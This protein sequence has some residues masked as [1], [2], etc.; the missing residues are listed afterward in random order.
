M[1]DF[2]EVLSFCDVHDIGFSG[3]PWTFDNKQRGERNVKVRLD[4]AVASPDWSIRFPDAKVHHLVSSRSDHCPLLVAMLPVREV[5]RHHQIRRYEVMWEREPSLA[6]TVEDAWSRRVGVHDLGDI[7]S[8]FHTIMGSLYDWKKK[9]FKPVS[10]EIEKKR[11]RL[12]EL[13]SLTDDDSIAARKQLMCEMDELLYRE[14]LMWMQRSR[15]AWLREGDRN[16]R[17][18]HRKATWRRKKNKILKLKR[19]DGSWAENEEEIGEMATSFF[20]N[21]YTKDDDVLPADLLHLFSPRVDDDMN[22]TLC[23]PFSEK[24]I[25]DALFQIGPLKAP[26]PDGFPARFLQRNWDLLKE[27]IIKAVQAF[28]SSGEMPEVVND[29]AIILIPKKNN[30]EELKDFRPISLCNVVFKI[31]SKCMV[32]RLRPLLHD[33]ISPMQSA[34][35]PGRLITDNALMAFECFHAI[36]SNS[37]D[38]SKFCAY[39]L[40]LAKAYD[41]VDW[42]YLEGVMTKLGFH[43]TWVRWIMQC[44]TTV[45]YSVRL[46]G[47]VLD[48]F[49]PTRGLRQG[50]PLSPYLFLL[51]ADGLS[52]LIQKE[53]EDGNLKELM[54]CR[55]APGM[56]HLLFADDSLLFF[57]G[58]VQQA[59][60][61]KSILNKYEKGTGQLVS[62][63]KCSIMYGRRVE[64]QAQ[65]EIKQILQYETESFD[66]KYLGLPV[67]EGQ[68]RKGKFKT[69]KERFQKRLSDW[70]EKYLSSGGKEVLIKAILQA[71][72]VYA[73]SVFQFPAGLVE[74]LN[75][76]IRNFH[77]GDEHDRRRMHWLSWDKLTQPK[78]NGGMGFRDFRVY[79][80]ALLARQA[81]RL[82]QFPDSPC[83]RLLKAKYYPSGHLL[84]TAF[85]QDVSATWKGVMHGLELLKQGAIW[86]VGSGSMVKIWR[87]N[88][89]PRAD[90]LKLSG[91]KERC[92]LKWVSQLIDPAT[93]TWDEATIRQ[94]CFPH[95]GE[96]ILQ[97]KLPHRRS[98]DFVAWHFES[99]GVFSVRSA[100]KLGMQ[101]KSQALSRGQSSHEAG[102]ERSI[103]NLV[104]KTPVPQKVR[105]FAWRLAT[106]SLAVAD[107]LHRRIPKILPICQICGAHTEDAHH[108]MVRCTL[109]RALRDSMRQVWTLPKEEDFRYTGQDWFLMLLNAAN[110]DMRVKLLFLFWRIWHH[111]NNVVHGD[112]KASIEASKSFLQNYLHSFQPGS[113]KPDHKGKAVMVPIKAATS[114]QVTEAPSEWQAP[115]SGWIKINVDAGWNDA[116]SAGGAGMV[117][118]DSLGWIVF[119]AWKTLPPCASA[120]EAEILACLEGILY[121]AAHPGCPGVLETD[122]ASLVSVLGAKEDDRSANWFLLLEA[123]TLMGMIP[124]IKI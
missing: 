19:P 1:Q 32:N 94:Y 15:V 103:W 62:L 30:P 96:A 67:P 110:K 49:T 105:I 59:S 92:R 109:A 72:P 10:K 45:R 9:H 31:I 102:G 63:G 5:R 108:A 3:V 88:W 82:L 122:C 25:S 14:E 40:D 86:R 55:R 27:D 41:R 36:Q 93:H 106:D 74:E 29:T 100:Y 111:R 115:D 80:Q 33:I 60:V 107:S 98:E 43:S 123:R 7:C 34:F 64:E 20:A 47:H 39:K 35:I 114:D 65:A 46:N 44:V 91:M 73:M 124:Q 83:A 16:T 76:L 61:V 58:S 56:S 18:F 101:P 50:D 78:L 81:W 22:Q 117:V 113:A 48:T 23:A 116:H 2:R 42:R 95:D 37:A 6:A 26:G 79:N 104:W 119:S 71:L 24:E 112:G 21:L 17:Y 11:K 4:R 38:R 118:R 68:M 28:F 54:I 89:L 51:V 77:W 85:I 13:L 90:N 53:V 70:V 87:D 66:E 120:E 99:S 52:R 84:D 69:L 97:I 75:Q 12:E 8:S 121:L 57:Q